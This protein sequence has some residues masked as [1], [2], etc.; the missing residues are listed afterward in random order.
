M[1]ERAE[2]DAR[3]RKRSERAIEQMRAEVGAKTEPRR[4]TEKERS[5][6]AACV[7]SMQRNTDSDLVRQR[8]RTDTRKCERKGLT[9]NTSSVCSAYF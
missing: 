6:V 1:N 9:S 2:E 3:E 4:E 5:K 8:G 7:A